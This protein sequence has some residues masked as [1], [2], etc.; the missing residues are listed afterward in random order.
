MSDDEMLPDS[1]RGAF[2][3]GVAHSNAKV[4]VSQARICDL[5][6]LCVAGAFAIS[7]LYPTSQAIWRWKV[8]RQWFGA[9]LLTLFRRHRICAR[10]AKQI[11]PQHRPLPLEADSGA[12]AGISAGHPVL[13]G[14]SAGF[15]LL[16][17][18]AAGPEDISLGAG[19][20]RGFGEFGSLGG[21]RH[22]RPSPCPVG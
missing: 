9:H 12:L 13:C 15:T 19:L 21:R 11:Q 10:R 14:L 6:N 16:H 4:T 1:Q 22:P 8:T 18:G 5:R 7:D 2:A 17:G 20:S 3:R